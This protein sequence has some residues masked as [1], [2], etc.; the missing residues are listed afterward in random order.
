MQPGTQVNFLKSDV[1]FNIHVSTQHRRHHCGVFGLEGVHW[2]D[3]NMELTMK[4]L[5]TTEHLH[6]SESC[7]YNVVIS[8]LQEAAHHKHNGNYNT[9]EHAEPKWPHCT[10]ALTSFTT[11]CFHLITATA[12]YTV[13]FI[14]LRLQ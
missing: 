5:R 4:P 7:R 14:P 2:V 10:A 1:F 13:F 12:F 11:L 9:D 8:Y 6:V 3:S